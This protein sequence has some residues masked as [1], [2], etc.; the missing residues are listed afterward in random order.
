MRYCDCCNA[1]VR[2][3]LQI[4]EAILTHFGQL[5]CYTDRL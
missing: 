2:R 5:R 1:I 3:V 4:N